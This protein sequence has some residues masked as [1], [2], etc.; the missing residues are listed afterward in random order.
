M[1]A[2][3]LPRTQAIVG[4]F[5]TDAQASAKGT[6]AYVVIPNPRGLQV[7]E[8]PFTNDLVRALRDAGVP[9]RSVVA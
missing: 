3:D 1:A 2:G 9:L 8:H 7:D 5:T 4:R 6:S